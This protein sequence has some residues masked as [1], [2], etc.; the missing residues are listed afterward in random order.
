MNKHAERAR[1]A[2]KPL[3]HCEI[4]GDVRPQNLDCHARGELARTA[5]EHERP[6]PDADQLV[7]V[8]AIRDRKWPANDAVDRTVRPTLRCLT[9]GT[10]ISHTTPDATPTREYS[11]LRSPAP[12]Y[13]DRSLSVDLSPDTISYPVAATHC[14]GLSMTGGRVII[15]KSAHRLSNRVDTEQV[16]TCSFPCAVLP[17]RRV[18][19]TDAAMKPGRSARRLQRQ[20]ANPDRAKMSILT[21]NDPGRLFKRQMQTAIGDLH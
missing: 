4:R 17:A 8:I 14:D 21:A 19:R 10:K 1:L 15:V 7:D 3:A 13:A 6:R 11:Y 5:A 20:I 18:A 9:K 2:N 16:I 12:R